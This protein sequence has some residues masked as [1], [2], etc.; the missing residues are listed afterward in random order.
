LLQGAYL[1]SSESKQIHHQLILRAP[2]ALASGF[3]WQ[4]RTSDFAL[5]GSASRLSLYGERTYL[6]PDLHAR[7]RTTIAWDHLPTC[8][9]ASLTSPHLVQVPVNPEGSTI[10]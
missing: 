4:Q 10:P 9:P 6:R 1:T 5:N 3:Y 7:P 8:V 2:V